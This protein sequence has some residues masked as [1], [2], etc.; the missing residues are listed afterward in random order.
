M[1]KMN[2]RKGK[3]RDQQR[4]SQVAQW[5]R[6]AHKNAQKKAA[7]KASYYQPELTQAQK[8]ELKRRTSTKEQVITK[9]TP[10]PQPSKPTY[11]AAMEA[12]SAGLPDSMLREHEERPKTMKEAENA[13]WDIIHT[14]RD[15]VKNAGFQYILK[16]QWLIKLE[17][18]EKGRF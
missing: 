15:K 17:E 4:D 5:E 9:P 3:E 2:Y 14:I 10:K 11:T 8:D 6:K 13:L 16:P 18:K 12:I 7:W 1:A